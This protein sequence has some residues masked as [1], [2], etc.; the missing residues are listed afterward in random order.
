MTKFIHFVPIATPEQLA[1]K[2]QAERAAFEE[3]LRET[4]VAILSR[5]QHDYRCAEYAQHVEEAR[6]MALERGDNPDEEDEE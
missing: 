4:E 5:R 2:R 3:V 1:A 6:K